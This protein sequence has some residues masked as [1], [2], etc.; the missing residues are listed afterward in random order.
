MITACW[1]ITGTSRGLG[2]ALAELLLQREEVEVH[3]FA[4]HAA[5]DH[6]RY[7]HHTVDLSDPQAVADIRFA[8][9]PEVRQVVL[10]NNAG[11]LGDILFAGDQQAVNITH[12]YQLDLITPHML[13]NAFISAFRE[14]DMRK[15]LINITSGAAKS[16]YAGWSIYCASKAGLDMLTLCIAKEQAEATYPCYVYAIA[17]GVMD[18]DMQTQIRSTEK[19]HFPAL[20][21]FA[22]LYENKQ[23][24]DVQAVAARYVAFADTCTGKEETIQRIVL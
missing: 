12:T 10:V 2:K 21:K 7:I 16:P 13:S 1:F 5:I 23:L 20:Q 17:P 11:A 9:S 15:I 24:Y 18:T 19:A 4:R 22:D 14:R 8:V 3:G 6:P